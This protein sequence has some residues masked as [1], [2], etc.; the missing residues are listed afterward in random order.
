MF[1]DGKYSN[2]NR[3]TIMKL[4]SLNVSIQNLDEV[5]RTVLKN[6]A[7]KNIDKL[8]STAMKCRLQEEA[9]IL[10]QLLVG[11][12][13]LDNKNDQNCLHGDGT[14][15]YH[16]HYQNFQIT[17]EGG[18]TLSFGLSEVAGCDAATV[19]HNFTETIEDLSVVMTGNKD[20]DEATFSKMVANIRTY[21]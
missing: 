3:E 18:R 4:L 11:E 2:E 5:I 6:L 21:V 19:M 8:L 7:H 13:L 12:A 15:K 20:V 16:R 1:H 10:A 17:T 9:L 14:S